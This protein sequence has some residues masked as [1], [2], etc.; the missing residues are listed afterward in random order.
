MRLGPESQSVSSASSSHRVTTRMVLK[1]WLPLVG[2]SSVI[3]CGCAP[4]RLTVDF[5]GFE[6]AYAETSNRELLLNL[7]RLQNHE[8]T[9][10]FKL[11]QVT[12]QYRMQATITGNAALTPQGTT[13][14]KGIVTEGGTP[15]V[16]FENDP[17]FQFIPVNDDT[18]A[19]LLLKP[20]PPETFYILYQQG[21]R[22]DQLFRLLVDRMEIASRPDK[23]PDA[24]G[25]VIETFRN[26]P[27]PFYANDT[28]YTRDAYQLSHYVTFL[29]V[30]AMM[31]VLQKNGMLVL[32][33]KYVFHPYD[34]DSGIP[35]E[36]GAAENTGKTGTTQNG[37]PQGASP[38]SKAGAPLAKDQNDAVGKN[39]VWHK[40]G[41]TWLL[42]QKEFVPMFYLNPHVENSSSN[43]DVN[44]PEHGLSPD[45]AKIGKKVTEELPELANGNALAQMLMALSHGFSIEGD[46]NSEEDTDGQ[47]LCP[48]KGG[49]S[50]HLVM[51]SMV[52]IMAAAAEEQIPFED[53]VQYN[54]EIPPDPDVPA[55]PSTAP[56]PHFANQV[57]Q[58]ELQPL[59]RLTWK[60]GPPPSPPLIRVNYRDTDYLIADNSNP[61]MPVNE[62][63]N[64][65]MFR[66]I[67]DLT[68]QV[69]VDISKF[70]LPETLQLHTD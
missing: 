22:L 62:Y 6:R 23:G 12:S 28:T 27:P 58:I 25:C 55:A 57:P 37:A 43:T 47:G 13:P 19:Q 31:Y 26:T 51:R 32:R 2:L 34:K 69:T 30:S 66:L 63:W 68:S 60:E 4:R 10:F 15:G 7:A 59:L 61:D 33:G 44:D 39:N 40:E 35:D 49:I 29:R 56:L 46:V 65:D 5:A 20:I 53:L 21:W 24:G 70:P 8:P 11:G 18:N 41:N 52:G 16:L 50:S 64:R 17:T 67:D 1:R 36:G 45:T 38:E 9:Y 3:L 54:P 14:G 48:P 42:G